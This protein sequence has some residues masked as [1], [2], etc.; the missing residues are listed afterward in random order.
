MQALELIADQLREVALLLS[1]PERIQASRGYPMPKST[2]KWENEG[3]S[4]EAPSSI[5]PGVVRHTEETF[6]VG[7]YRYTNLTAA[8]AEVKRSGR[9]HKS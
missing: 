5:P 3:G 7:S 9:L 2:D 4:L 1:V 6:T 8:V